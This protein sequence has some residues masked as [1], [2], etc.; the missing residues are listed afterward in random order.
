MILEFLRRLACYFRRRRLED[1]L[2][3]EMR[4]HAELAGRARFGNITRWK[5]ESRAM[6]GWTFAEQFAQDLRY[7]LRAMMNN[8]TFTALAAL[9]LALGI[10]A[11][12]AIFSFMDA[13]LLRSLPVKDPESLVVLNWRAKAFGRPRGA[14]QPVASVV[15]RI[16][17]SINPD[18]RGGV[19]SA[20]FPYPAFELLQ[21]KDE[22]FSS[23]F[24][25]CPGPR[26]LNAKI[27]GLADLGDSEYV[28]GDYFRALGVPP[29]AG[30][31]LTNDDDR[32]GAPA[33]A[34]LS[35]AYARKRFGDPLKA[36]GTAV[37]LNDLPFTIVGVAPPEFF[38]VDPA[39]APDVYL[40]LH[41]S[42]LFSAGNRFRAIPELQDRQ[43]YWVQ[44]MA[45]LRP[46]VSPAQAQAALAPVFHQWVDS[47]ASNDRERAN[48]PGLV[49]APGAA[50]VDSL[51]R[52]FSRP[53][54]VLLALVGLILAI[55]CANI[56]NLLLA[57]ATARRREIAVRL[58]IGAGRL[59]VIRQL[60]TESVLLA[61]LGGA[62]GI[63][64]AIWGTRVLTLLLANGRQ[65]FTLHAELNWHVLA[66]AAGLS[67]L[68]GILFGLAP[69]IQSTRV[70]VIP[71][72]K[73]DLRQPARRAAALAF[74]VS[75]Q[76]AIAL[77]VLVAAGLFIRTLSNLNSIQIG[78][79]RENLLLFQV[80]ARQAGHKDPEIADFYR[81]LQTQ[82]QAIPGVR[83][84]TLSLFSMLN[85]GTMGFQLKVHGTRTPTPVSILDVGPS[86]FAT[87]QI[88]ILVGNDIEDR[89]RA[90][91]VV[92]E[93]FAK[94]YFGD[95]NPVG[96]HIGAPGTDPNHDDDV[97]IVGVCANAK[98]GDLRDQRDQYF[99]P[100]AYFLYSHVSFPQL[101]QMVFEVRTA[102]NPLN[103]VN[104]V[105]EIVRG[106]DPGVPVSNIKTEAAEIGERTN[107]ETIFARLSSLFAFLALAITCV[108]LY[109]TVSY[110]VARRTNEIGIRMALGAQRTGVIRMILRDVLTTILIGFAIGLPVAL[111]TSK[112][113]ASFLYGMKPNDPTA[114][115]AA[116]AAL[117][118][119]VLLAGYAP[120]RRASRI[121]PMAALRHE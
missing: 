79:N 23:L 71:A 114:L 100:T 83:G 101:G 113:V 119:A 69:A 22:V 112:F 117:V 95:E 58:S 25:Y 89:G 39:A 40:P 76:I 62:L 91:A 74:L 19:V 116:A 3:E 20:I 118:A 16:N 41:A 27:N 87:M 48:L 44:M 63:V 13:I 110:N 5:E 8:R 56:A 42:A 94:T 59:R 53:L 12:T 6:W 65:N 33:V 9:S 73:N 52:Q 120:A 26:Q 17:G 121:D 68:T 72:L 111:A 30:R 50:G 31:L 47:T 61:S 51:R 80:N 98:Y 85:G 84:A 60:L 38:G 18:P 34:V 14:R 54:F 96:Q 88:P 11:N 32:G 10:G 49:L 90:I 86:F 92:D 81:N 35:F 108:G 36:V 93:T 2:D 15:Q 99:K 67:V 45:R 24:G 115:T 43:L 106:A 107:Q 109:G 7:A 4:H 57:R 97:E 66:V 29:A 55:A 46:G 28:S 75:G 77:L 82:F 104:T 1:D 64:L 37:S 21:K 70:D 102:G 78:F 105:R 103:Y